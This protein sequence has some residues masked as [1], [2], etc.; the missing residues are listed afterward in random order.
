MIRRTVLTTVMLGL[1]VVCAS[2]AANPSAGT[3]TE[4]PSPDARRTD[5]VYKYLDAARADLSDGKAK[6]INQVMTLSTDESAKFWPIYKE[7]EEEL[8]DLGDQRVE[9]T[10]KF[11]KAQAQHSLDDAAATALADDWFRF[12]SQRLELVKKYHKRIAA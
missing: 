4:A 12:E 3:T 2:D 6:L 8:F 1:A 5:P 9:M 7:Y 10:R 11:V